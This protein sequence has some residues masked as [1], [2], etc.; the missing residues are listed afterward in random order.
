[1]RLVS[2]EK[3]KRAYRDMKVFEYRVL[4]IFFV[5]VQYQMTSCCIFDCELGVISRDYRRRF[6]FGFKFVVRM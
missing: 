3:V 6:S 2:L 5:V 4:G 1:M